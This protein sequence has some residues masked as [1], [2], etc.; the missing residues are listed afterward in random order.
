MTK[1]ISRA[2][3]EKR[4]IENKDKNFSILLIK[5]VLARDKDMAF[6]VRNSMARKLSLRNG[7]EV[8]AL[9]A[10]SREQA[11]S[12]CATNTCE[13]SSWAGGTVQVEL[14]LWKERRALTVI[15]M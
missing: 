15:D 11:R 4:H 6:K 9:R 5:S 14:R 1:N 3:G 12:D 7:E 10:D 13:G 8:T 2:D